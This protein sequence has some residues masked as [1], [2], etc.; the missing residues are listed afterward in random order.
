MDVREPVTI[1]VGDDEKRFILRHTE[2]V[3]ENLDRRR[4][5]ART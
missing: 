4:A 5:P 1:T 3:E 2:L